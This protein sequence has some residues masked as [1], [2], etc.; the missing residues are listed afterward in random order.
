MDEP[1]V[2]V[3]LTPLDESQYYGRQLLV[4]EGGD[5]A[6]AYDLLVAGVRNLDTKVYFTGCSLTSNEVVKILRYMIDDHPEM[7]WLPNS[8][9]YSS[10]Y[11]NLEY[12]LTA[13]EVDDLL[14][15]LEEASQFYLEGLSD[16]SS[17][18][19]RRKTIHDRLIEN[20]DYDYEGYSTY[21]HE[22]IG[23]MLEG[24]GVCESYARAYQYLLYRAGILS[25]CVTGNDDGTETPNHIWNVV[26]ANGEWLMTDVTWDDASWGPIYSNYDFTY[27]EAEST[28]HYIIVTSYP[29]PDYVTV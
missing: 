3:T 14:A 10:R 20:A 16:E 7:F 15:Q 9:S 25:A 4:A 27:A 6:K 5:L 28:D 29:L 8:F 12:A 2:T 11:I 22:L 26:Y 13:A 1:V 23:V 17:V 19:E 24:Y 18:D 21:P